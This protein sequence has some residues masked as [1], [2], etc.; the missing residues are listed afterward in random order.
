MMMMI[1][2]TKMNKKA[3]TPV[4][5]QSKVRDRIQE[6]VREMYHEPAGGDGVS[7]RNDTCHGEGRKGF[8][9]Y[10]TMDVAYEGM[11]TAFFRTLAEAEQSFED[12]KES[13]LGKLT[14]E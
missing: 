7:V 9:W 13:G 6:I 11:R 1:T 4:N 5:R 14:E 12:W 10:T 2:G 8:G 3:S